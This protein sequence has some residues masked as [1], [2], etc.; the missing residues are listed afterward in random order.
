[1]A[2]S[3]RQGRTIRKQSNARQLQHD[4]IQPMKRYNKCFRQVSLACALL[5]TTLAPPAYAVTATRAYYP[6]ILMA[7]GSGV[8][9]V[10]GQKSINSTSQNGIPATPAMP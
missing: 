3:A 6:I 8:S 7:A 2:H 9:P 5:L 1:M 4:I 10:P